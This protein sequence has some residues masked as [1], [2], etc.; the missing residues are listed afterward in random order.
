MHVEKWGNTEVEGIE[1]GKVYVFPKLDGT[2][3]SLWSTRDDDGTLVWGGSRNRQL[4]I[5]NDNAGFYNSLREKPV[6]WDF[7]RKHPNLRLY[8]EW[9]VPH[10]LKTYREDV[11]RRF[12]I[13]DV[14]NDETDTW[15]DYDTYKPML[16]EFGLDY[17][18]PL[19]IVTN[20]DYSKF[21]HTLQLNRLF[22][23]DGEGV[24]EGVVLK[25]Y[26]Y[27]NKFGQQIWAKLVTS[28]FKE[29]HHREMGAPE[30][31]GKLLEEEIAEEYVTQALVDKVYAKIQNCE[32]GWNSR[33]IPRLLETVYH[34]L[35]RE[36]TYEVLKTYKNP[37]INFKTLKHF[38]I[39]RVKELRGEIF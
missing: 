3:A 28:E 7:F 6:Y 14:Y 13:F 31:K 33:H 38:T 21:I 11:W 10:T 23:Q 34:D 2:N 15:L 35:I 30:S 29:N 19:A 8:G 4:S 20:G 37:T 17:I 24:G 18:P 25:N 12:W 1:F 9:L 27:Y 39:A 22:I 36:E 5:E 16:D 26:N 32:G